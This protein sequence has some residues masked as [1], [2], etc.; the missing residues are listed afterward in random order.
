MVFFDSDQ[1]FTSGFCFTEA[2]NI[3]ETYADIGAVGWGGGWFTLDGEDLV[4]PVVDYFPNRARNAEM[5]IKGFRTDVP[6]LSTAGL[7]VP[8]TIFE[9]AGGF[10]TAYDPTSF[11]DTDLS[12][13]IKKLGFKIAYR[14][15]TGI[16]HEAHQT[17]KSHEKS[18]KYREVFSRNSQYFTNKWS[19]YRQFFSEKKKWMF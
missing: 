14:D 6:Y 8:R 1:W 4:G 7:F 11:E 13:A 16:R 19:D 3:L 12:F 18:P 2:L 5:S 17:T 10:D 9:A 15:L